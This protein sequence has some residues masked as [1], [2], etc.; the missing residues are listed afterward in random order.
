MW[1]EVIGSE[2]PAMWKPNKKL[3]YPDYYSNHTNQ[4]SSVFSQGEEQAHLSNTKATK[5]LPHSQRSTF[6]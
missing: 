6:W 5:V 4:C 1:N 2:P 3:H